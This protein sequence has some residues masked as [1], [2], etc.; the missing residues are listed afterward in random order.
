NIEAVNEAYNNVLIEE[1]DYDTLC[2]SI[3]SSDRYDSIA[4]A[5]RLEQHELLEFR[6][7][8]AHLYKKNKQ[9]D[10][11][12]TSSKQDKLFKDA[13][14]TAAVS[15][16]TEVAEDLLSISGTRCALP[17]CFTSASICYLL[18]SLWTYL[19]N[20]ASTTSI[21]PIRFNPNVL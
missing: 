18:T 16:S 2:D 8:A 3:D 4:L 7:L 6:R 10:I 15:G 21:C 14:I 19:G 20:M 9:W 11:S 17:L 12:I 1:E 13:I 5:K